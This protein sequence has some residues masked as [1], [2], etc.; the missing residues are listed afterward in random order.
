MNKVF[1]DVD[2]ALKEVK[3]LMTI[4]EKVDVLAWLALTAV[5]A[6]IY[7]IKLRNMK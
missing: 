6:E 7:C 1:K 4:A 3:S 5:Y 2:A